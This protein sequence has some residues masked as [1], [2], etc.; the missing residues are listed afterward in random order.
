VIILPI[1][2]SVLM[3]SNSRQIN[4][5]RCSKFN[6]I[7]SGPKRSK[8]STLDQLHE[9]HEFDLKT[10]LT[11]GNANGYV[12]HASDGKPFLVRYS[13]PVIKEG[14]LKSLTIWLVDPS[15][16][17]KDIIGPSY[18][19][20]TFSH[21]FVQDKNASEDFLGIDESGLIVAEIVLTVD[22]SGLLYLIDDL[23]YKHIT[24]SILGEYYGSYRG[25]YDYI[26]R[27]MVGIA[28]RVLNVVYG[29]GV[30]GVKT[31]KT[32]GFYWEISGHPPKKPVIPLI[33]SQLNRIRDLKIRK[34]IRE[35]LYV[36]IIK[37]IA[38]HRFDPYTGLCEGFS[39][40]YAWESH[41]NEI[42]GILQD[43]KPLIGRLLS[44]SRDVTM[45]DDVAE[46]IDQ[47]MTDYNVENTEWFNSI[48]DGLHKLDE[49]QHSED[50]KLA[51]SLIGEILINE[52][53]TVIKRFLNNLSLS[54][55]KDDVVTM[56][57]ETINQYGRIF[58]IFDLS[59][60]DEIK[61]GIVLHKKCNA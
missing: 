15:V 51:A 21:F 49:A 41:C 33:A 4:N 16:S 23:N 7:M 36:T 52:E 22:E 34:E 24:D 20:E 5:A 28:G 44:E 13:D 3:V 37:N 26:G 46:F 1:L 61:I 25:Q 14:R 54:E 30:L 43:N 60:I 12:I 39:I 56:I 11:E 19:S 38:L 2:F 58:P 47:M 55:I 8:N 59:R 42:Q 35:E 29:I 31:D 9:D 18:I 57:L 48:S 40:E 50:K 45:A 17:K 32:R 53:D 27:S 10:F 6:A